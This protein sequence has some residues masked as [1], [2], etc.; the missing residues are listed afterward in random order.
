M[1]EIILEYSGKVTDQGRLELPSKRLAQEIKVFSGKEVKVIIRRKK[2]VRSSL[3]N[4]YYWG[5]MV[6][7]VL[8]AL[9][10]IG[11]NELQSGNPDSMQ[12]VHEFLKGKFLIGADIVDT[13]GNVERLP[14]T[15]QKLSTVEFIDYKAD[16]QQW[17]AEFLNIIIPDPNEQIDFDF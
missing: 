17:A 16:I 3:Q 5:C 4:R 15:T 1:K 12:I 13:Q 7:M 11:H 14:P 9:V 8:D 2:K 6:R 10:D